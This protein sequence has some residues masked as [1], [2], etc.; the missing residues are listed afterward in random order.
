MG[1]VGGGGGWRPILYELLMA[2][3]FV[4]KLIEV[5]MNK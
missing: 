2:L 3:Y 5:V 1:V 4:F